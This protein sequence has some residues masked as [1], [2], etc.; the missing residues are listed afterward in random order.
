MIYYS[1]ALS[2]GLL[3]PAPIDPPAIFRPAPARTAVSL[4]TSTLY[5]GLFGDD[6]VTYK[7]GADSLDLDSLLDSVPSD[8]GGKKG[9]QR[10]AQGLK[11]LKERQAEEQAAA[12]VK[13]E[14][15]LA[16]EAAG[17]E[18]SFA[19]DVKESANAGI[20]AANA[21]FGR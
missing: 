3:V 11:R 4:P 20:A 10:D 19:G 17:K 21:L 14:A 13:Y 2:L 8:P 18:V 1:I 5:S 7:G 9:A 16:M 15:V 6:P 12:A